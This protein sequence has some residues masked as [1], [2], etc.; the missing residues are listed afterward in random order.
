MDIGLKSF[1]ITFAVLL[2]LFA[3][4]SWWADLHPVPDVGGWRLFG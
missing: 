4:F 3:L 1:L 2:I